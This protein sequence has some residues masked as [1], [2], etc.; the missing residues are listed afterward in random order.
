ML[1]G[2]GRADDGSGEILMG[3][4]VIRFGL[5]DGGLE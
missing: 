1:R 5:L 4:V 3:A 2:I